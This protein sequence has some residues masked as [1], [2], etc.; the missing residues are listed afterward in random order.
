[1]SD[2]TLVPNLEILTDGLHNDVKR[3]LPSIVK[4]KPDGSPSLNREG[5][6][7]TIYNTAEN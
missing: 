5:I 7:N 1:M 2:L 4:K 6:S 3:I